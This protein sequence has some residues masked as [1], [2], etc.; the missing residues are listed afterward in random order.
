[1]ASKGSYVSGTDGTDFQHRQRVVSSHSSS[2]LAKHYLKITF[3]LHFLLYLIII[4]KLSEDI[5]DR[6]D[7]FILELQELA[8]PKPDLWEW[9]YGLSFLFTFFGARSF[10]NNSIAMIKIYLFA[11]V[12]LT[13]GPIIMAQF[14]YSNDF[15]KFISERNTQHLQYVWRDIPIAVVF[16]AFTIIAIQIHLF[17]IYFAYKLL[18]IWSSYSRKRQLNQSQQQQQSISVQEQKLKKFQ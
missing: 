2:I 8:I 16:E 3:Y 18:K 6:M 13:I 14:Q 11:I 5:L 17:Q 1:M 9:A 10:R 12:T 7:I 15:I 4:L